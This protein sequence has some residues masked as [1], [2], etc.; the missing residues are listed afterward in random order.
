[1]PRAFVLRSMKTNVNLMVSC[2]HKCS[3]VRKSTCA[4]SKLI[5]SLIIVSLVHT[6]VAKL[7]TMSINPVVIS[8]SVKQTATVST[9]IL[10]SN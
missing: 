8:S 1:M 9:I 4:S 6:S 2:N 7:N 5:F 10:F 3:V